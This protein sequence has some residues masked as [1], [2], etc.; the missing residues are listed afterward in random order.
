[1]RNV[2]G[3]IVG[4]SLI[5]GVLG[6]GDA[7]AASTFACDG[8]MTFTDPAEN[9]TG[10]LLA[11]DILVDPATSK[12]SGRV[13]WVGPDF[14]LAGSFDADAQRTRAQFGGAMRSG[15]QPILTRN[16]AFEGPPLPP[17]LAQGHALNGREVRQAVVN[18]VLVTSS[19][20]VTLTVDN[21]VD[22]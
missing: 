21:C 12:L 10:R 9:I 13:T 18:N 4:V 7:G 16:F 14:L 5:L 2:A 20:Q 8:P 17:D 6:P 3:V 11:S 1:M 19:R 15:A 22:P